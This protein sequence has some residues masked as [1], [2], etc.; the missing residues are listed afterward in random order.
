MTLTTDD[1][2]HLPN[3]IVC[4][5]LLENEN[6][7]E[8]NALYERIKELL[9]R[10]TQAISP[11]SQRTSPL[12]QGQAFFSPNAFP[13]EKQEEKFSVMLDLARLQVMLFYN[14]ATVARL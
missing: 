2:Y 11:I 13:R 7:P 8:F 1:P 10:K 14:N 4:R 9:G 6:S 12:S 5:E 3:E